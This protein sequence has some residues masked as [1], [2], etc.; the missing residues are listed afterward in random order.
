MES[1]ALYAFVDVAPGRTTVTAST[2]G[3]TQQWVVN[4]PLAVSAAA[5]NTHDLLKEVEAAGAVGAFLNHLSA[6]T[7]MAAADHVILLTRHDTAV[8]IF[9]AYVARWLRAACPSTTPISFMPLALYAARRS[10]VET[11]LVVE[12][13]NG[14]VTCTP[15]LDGI[16]ASDVAA[17]WGDVSADAPLHLRTLPERWVY[18]A[19][20]LVKV[21]SSTAAVDV[22]VADG[23]TPPTANAS[24]VR[25]RAEVTG[26]ADLP[27]LAEVGEHLLLCRRRELS[28]CLATVVLCGDTATLV[29]ARYAVGLLLSLF[30][31]HSLVT[32]C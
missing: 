3:E 2:S 1:K 30:L 9:Y 19:H 26:T 17:H 8:D 25:N 20:R 5:T 10:N 31:P 18:F 16:V 15:I 13:H 24:V 21:V 32:W 4:T 14:V 7:H 23:S 22:A 27:L 29:E 6:S 11:A 28:P 12:S